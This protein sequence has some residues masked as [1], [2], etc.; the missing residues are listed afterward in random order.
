MATFFDAL[1]KTGGATNSSNVVHALF[2]AL[3][4]TSGANIKAI[5]IHALFVA[6]AK[7]GGALAR[8][9]DLMQNQRNAKAGDA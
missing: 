9:L 4:K 3:P 6:L 8:Q 5:L 7:T 2:V 1:A